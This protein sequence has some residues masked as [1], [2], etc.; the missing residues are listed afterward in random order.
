MG[1]DVE[2]RIDE[3]CAVDG[4]LVECGVDVVE[5][6]VPD[7]DHFPSCRCHSWPLI[8]L[9]WNVWRIAVVI[10]VKW[11]ESTKGGPSSAEL[12]SRVVCVTAYIGPNHWNLV[13][14]SKGQHGPDG[15]LIVWPIAHIVTKPMADSGTC[16]SKGT[17]SNDD[18][19][20]PW[21]TI[22]HGSLGGSRHHY[23]C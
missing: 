2:H 16:S 22:Q 10:T 9:L 17:A 15:D 8:E 14:G 13:D 11:R 5:E 3:G 20:I 6:A 19:S 18:R 7:V 21:A 1:V 4:L 12:F 23:A